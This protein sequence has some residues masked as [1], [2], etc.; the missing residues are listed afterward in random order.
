MMPKFR[1]KPVVIEAVQWTGSNL[2]EVITFTDGKPDIRSTHAGMKWDDYCDLVRR[3]GLKIFTLEGKMLANPG[4]WIIRG[5]KGELYPCKPDIFAATYE[6]EEKSSAPKL[7]P[8][9]PEGWK[10]VPMRPTEEMLHILISEMDGKNPAKWSH[11]LFSG[12]WRDMLTAA[13]PVP[14]LTE[15]QAGAKALREVAAKIN[16]RDYGRDIGWWLE[17]TKKEVAADAC[18][19]CVE[20]IYAEADRLERES[21]Q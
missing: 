3:D 11:S 7:A 8:V 12:I 20:F 13:P 15:A 18:R 6:P 2:F 5:V 9:V 16:K 17:A 10:L 21:G 4:D 19:E 14:S 1:K